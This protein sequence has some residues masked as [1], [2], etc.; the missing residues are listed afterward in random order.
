MRDYFGTV[1]EE[2]WPAAAR[3]VDAV[4][5]WPAAWGRAE[6]AY[7]LAHGR[8]LYQTL[9]AEPLKQ[10]RYDSA[11][12]A[13][14]SD[15]SFSLENVVKGFDWASLGEGLV[16]DVGGGIGSASRALAEA[17]TRLRFV[18]Q[19][20][21]EVVRSA[22]VED[23]GIR[24]RIQFVAHDFFQVQPVKEADVY[25]FRRVMMEWT[26]EKAAEILKALKPALKK[27]ALVQ[28]QDPYLPPPGLCPLWQE[29]KYRDSDTL[30][31]ALGS[32][33]SREEDEWEKIFHLAGPGFDFKG[34]R[35]VSGSNVAFIEAVWQGESASDPLS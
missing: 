3:L 17:F 22:V 10:V 14:S 26:E 18:V 30:A 21:E 33:G 9:E 29:R 8:T 34:V 31:F 11:M 20:R 7:V 24:D 12:G 4:E 25:F 32:A 19:D 23:E 13:F 5:T 6:S 15:R 16:V 27:G 28:I 35:M 2:I 1:C